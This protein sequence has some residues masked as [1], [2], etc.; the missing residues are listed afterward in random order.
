MVSDDPDGDI[1]GKRNRLDRDALAD[2]RR[3]AGRVG[4]ALIVVAVIGGLSN[5]GIAAVA[6]AIQKAG[7]PPQPPANMTRDEKAQWER[8]KDAAPA[9]VLCGSVFVSLVYLPVFLG[10]LKLQQGQG[11]GLGMT[12]AVMAMLPCSAAFLVGLPVGIW[13]F[14]VLSQPAVKEA[15]EPPPPR[16][17]RPPRDKDDGDDQPRRRRRDED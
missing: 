3:K 15:L 2:A 9:G 17:R 16:K 8:G 5:I 1:N 10:G 14:V 12:A 6:N 4:V 11:R 13:A 7:P